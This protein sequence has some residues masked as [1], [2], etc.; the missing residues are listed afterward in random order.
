MA[1]QRTEF[2]EAFVT[3]KVVSNIKPSNALGVEGM[4]S[5]Y[6]NVWIIKS[7]EMKFD[8]RPQLTTVAS[9]VSGV[10]QLPQYARTA[11]CD[12]W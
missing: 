11:S 12:D 2:G 7:A 4:G 10:P 5:G 3:R 1:Q 6:Q 8:N 9:Q